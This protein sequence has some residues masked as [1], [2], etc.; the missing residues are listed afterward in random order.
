M[1]PGR[2]PRASRCHGREGGEA[3]TCVHDVDVMFLSSQEQAL[4]QWLCVQVQVA[5]AMRHE[6]W[7]DR[8]QGNES[9]VELWG[10]G[11]YQWAWRRA[12]ARCSSGCDRVNI[13]ATVM[14]SRVTFSEAS[15]VVVR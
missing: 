15:G 11:A 1:A 12:S 6:G 8:H 7:T 13:T 3:T 9:K 2:V 4:F 14:V 10:S 5:R